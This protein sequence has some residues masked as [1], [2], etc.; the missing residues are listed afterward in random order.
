MQRCCCCCW[1]LHLIEFFP[2][3]SLLCEHWRRVR[4]RHSVFDQ[5]VF[6]FVEGEEERRGKSVFTTGNQRISFHSLRFI[7]CLIERMNVTTPS[8]SSKSFVREGE[9][10]TF[11]DH[12]DVIWPSVFGLFVALALGW[13]ICR[14][15]C[16]SKERSA[17]LVRCCPKSLCQPIRSCCRTIYRSTKKHRSFFSFSPDIEWRLSRLSKPVS[18]PSTS[19]PRLSLD[20]GR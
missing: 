1:S 5:D 8:V 9:K 20:S 19:D 10:F 13:M 15:K 11:D 2:I 7:E 4:V 16:S 17:H 18:E 3:D 6:S 14:Y 12:Q